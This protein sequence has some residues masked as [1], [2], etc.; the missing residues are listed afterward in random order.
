[1][2]D[3]RTSDENAIGTLLDTDLIRIARPSGALNFK[4]TYAQLKAQLNA[5]L[6][7][8]VTGG[9][10]LSPEQFADGQSPGS[11]SLQLLSSLGYSQLAAETAWP[12][13]TARWGSI[14]V[15][16]TSLDDVVM[17]EACCKKEQSNGDASIVCHDNRVYY[18][19]KGVFLARTNG[20]SS[21]NRKFIFKISE[22]VHLNASGGP[23]I[24]FDR[25][26]STQAQ[27]AEDANNFIAYQYIFDTMK[28][29][30]F[31]GAR[32]DG[33]IAVR[34]G[35]SYLPIFKN[36]HVYNFDDGIQFF[37]CL[38]GK[39]FNCNISD[40][41]GTGIVFATGV[42]KDGTPLW[43]DADLNNSASN[44]CAVIGGSKIRVG[45]GAFAGVAAYGCDGVAIG[46]DAQGVFEGAD[47]NSSPPQTNP[48]HHVYIDTQGSS[49]VNTCIISN[50]HVE[51][52]VLKSWFKIKSHSQ[53]IVAIIE[54]MSPNVANPD[55]IALID[56]ETHPSNPGGGSIEVV[57]S[58]IPSRA[59][60]WIMR[61]SGTGFTW[62]DFDK[63]KLSDQTA[64][65]LDAAGNWST[66]TIDGITGDIPIDS[67]LTILRTAH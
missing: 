20:R 22:G 15:N 44:G 3:T 7:I 43:T 16:N 17:Q 31:D 10:H 60:N 46:G 14:D 51:Q 48:D 1:M 49:T 18:Y 54:R 47:E 21:A 40:N 45:A 65:N 55:G 39:I 11:G 36:C 23:L 37:Y 33:D 9:D 57:A 29:V 50:L 67:F 30:G 42:G 13:S 61:R 12:L 35:A 66:D 6:V 56:A 34:L 2:A 52:Q 25:M 41:L 28:F 63:V 59:Y 4:M 26:P 53:G 62:F 58:M 5:E 32:G 8:A 27:A 19:K 38:H 64:G 24:L